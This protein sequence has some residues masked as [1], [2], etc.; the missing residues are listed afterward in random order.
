[1]RIA[2]NVSSISARRTMRQTGSKIEE[3][4]SELSSGSRIT[5]AADDAA[6]LAIS[7]GLRAKIRSKGQARRN[8]NDSISFLQIANGG[9]TEVNNILVRV[10]ELSVQSANDS[11]SNHERRLMDLEYNE[12][13]REVNRIAGSI[14]FNGKKLLSGDSVELNFQVDTENRAADRINYNSSKLNTSMSAL[15]LSGTTL[16]SKSSSQQLITKVDRA[17][18]RI[19]ERRSELGAVERRLNSTIGNIDMAEVN[20]SASNSRIRDTDFAMSTSKKV[21]NEIIL[22]ANIAS[23]SQAN[24]NP[25]LAAKMLG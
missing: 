13:S 10:K 17:I 1:M 9:L 18:S 16:S 25:A 3:A 22:N 21:K 12:L 19:S 7:E 23:L 5:K 20:L 15:G 11:I 14:D 24:A 4:Y 6:G 8:A 2:T